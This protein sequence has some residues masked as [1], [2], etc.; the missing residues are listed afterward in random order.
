MAASIDFRIVSVLC[1]ALLSCLVEGTDFNV[2]DHGAKSDGKS[3]CAKAFLEA[4]QAACHSPG[5]ARLVIP[6]GTFVVSEAMFTGPCTGFITVQLIGTIQ[7]TT[8]TQYKEPEWLGFEKLTGF[9]LTGGGTFD[10]QGQKVWEHNSSKKAVNLKFRHITNGTVTQITS[11]NPKGFHMCINNCHFFEATQ[12]KILAPGD[13]PNTDGMHISSSN[14]VTISKSLI[15]TGD[16]CI[17]IIQG[18]TGLHITDV[19][20]GPGHG[21]SVGSLGKYQNEEDVSDIF[22]TNCTL[23]ETTNGVRIKTWPGSPPSAASNIN[24]EDII[25]KNVK[26]PI[27]I[28]QEYCAAGSCGKASKASKVKISNVKFKNIRGTSTSKVAVN[29]RCSPEVP[30]SNVELF[31]IDLKYVGAVLPGLSALSE[32]SNVKVGCGGILNPPPC[33]SSTRIS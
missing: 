24:F 26:N 21:I 23:S 5:S 22:V 13:S 32:C 2:L 29:M 15:S 28:D 27:I 19:T 25:M 33:L 6:E 3:D 16:D 12:I 7:A 30:C 17:S 20:C 31:D 1:L 9:L 8:G 11:L 4:W 18:D 10:G 14:N